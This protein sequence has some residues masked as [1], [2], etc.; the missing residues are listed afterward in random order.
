MSEALKVAQHKVTSTQTQVDEMEDANEKKRVELEQ[1]SHQIVQ[2]EQ[3]QSAER[4]KFEDHLAGLISCFSEA[5]AFY[6]VGNITDAMELTEEGN[7]S[8]HQQ[9]G[10]VEKEETDLARQLEDLQLQKGEWQCLC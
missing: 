9:R 10:T 3:Q 8:L 1:I 5:K 6:S 4:N 7:M 2:E